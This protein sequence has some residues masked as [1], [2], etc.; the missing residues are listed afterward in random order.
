MG[1]GTS[2][3]GVCR[4]REI[5]WSAG[6]PTAREDVVASLG[7]LGQAE[8]GVAGERNGLVDLNGRLE[9]LTAEAMCDESKERE[10]WAVEPPCV[11]R[12]RIESMVRGPGDE[13]GARDGCKGIGD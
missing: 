11:A 13:G 8:A 10:D 9:W 7:T 1:V 6:R 12:S 2:G 5:G 4:V 3:I